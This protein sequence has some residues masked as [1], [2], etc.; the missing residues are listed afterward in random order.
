MR[1]ILLGLIMLIGLS[2]IAYG[3]R[4]LDVL[5]KMGT[6]KKARTEVQARKKKNPIMNMKSLSKQDFISGKYKRVIVPYV[7]NGAVKAVQADYS[8]GKY[9]K[10][11][12]IPRGGSINV[13]VKADA[14]TYDYWKNKGWY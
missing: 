6:S 9:T 11:I 10:V 14:A 7:H 2:D 8:S 12:R 3:Q 5:K 13:S 1:H 4:W